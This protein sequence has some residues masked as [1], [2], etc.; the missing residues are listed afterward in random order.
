MSFLMPA[1]ASFNRDA[2]PDYGTVENSSVIRGALKRYF[3]SSAANRS[4][5]HQLAGTESAERT[6]SS[7]GEH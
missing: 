3:M 4:S 5:H 6:E 1:R 2:S 7:L